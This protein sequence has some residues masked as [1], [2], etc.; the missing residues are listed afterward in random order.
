MGAAGY[1]APRH[2]KAIKETGNQL[3]LSMDVNDSIGILDSI[4][5]GSEFFVHFERFLD[6]AYQLGRAKETSLDYVSICTPNFLHHSHITS[7]LRLGCNVI[8]E[9]PLVPT[10]ELLR[11]LELVEYETGKKVFNIL[12]LRHH[13]SIINLKKKVESAGKVN[14]YDVDLTYITSRGSWYLESWKGNAAKSFGVATNIGI[15]FFDMLHFVFGNFQKNNVHYSDSMR[16]SGFSEYEFARVRWF[17]SIDSSDLPNHLKGVKQTYRNISV[18]GE[19]IEF[20]EG[21]TD[22]HTVSYEAVLNG[23]GFGLKDA[24]LSVQM[25]ELIRSANVCYSSEFAHPA[26]NILLKK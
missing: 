7:A 9:K 14:K 2:M 15:H 8:C 12:Q 18:N 5:P 11:D 13:P 24:E 1:I 6:R 20:S 17:L 10:V 16:I 25:S 22:L 4:F 23:A 26:L 19:E 3:I 21:F